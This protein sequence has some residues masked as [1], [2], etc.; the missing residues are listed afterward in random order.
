MEIKRHRGFL[1]QHG[2]AICKLTDRSPPD[3]LNIPSNV[4]LNIVGPL[5]QGIR[6]SDTTGFR[7]FLHDSPDP[8]IET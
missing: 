1:K 5:L 2:A 6:F 3:K 8:E 4:G 7:N